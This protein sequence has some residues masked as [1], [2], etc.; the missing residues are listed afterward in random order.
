M[1]KKH[2]FYGSVTIGERGQVVIP[3]QA[4]QDL[5][6]EPGEKLLVIRGG[7]M[8]NALLFAKA[9]QVTEMISKMT[10]HLGEIEKALKEPAD[11]NEKNHI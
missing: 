7:P 3:A 10:S 2:K 8:G 1:I 5:G 4:R 9:D 11:E 6:L